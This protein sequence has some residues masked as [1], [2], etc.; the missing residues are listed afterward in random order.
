VTG[1]PVQLQ[2][3]LLN[4]VLN[5]LDAIRQT[6]ATPRRIDIA[7]RVVDPDTVEVSVRDTGPGLPIGGAARVF[8]RF[9][10]TKPEGM[11]MGLAIARSIIEAHSGTLNAENVA[12]EAARARGYL[13]SQL[14]GAR[15]WFRLPVRVTSRVE[16]T[17]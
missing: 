1:D 14:R 13:P 3:V 15:F 4:L 2:Q 7:T 6:P 16:T 8:E 9:Y 10:S 12:V 5:A 17:A 11:G